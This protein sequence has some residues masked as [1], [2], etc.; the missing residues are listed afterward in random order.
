MFLHCLT[1]LTLEFGGLLFTAC[2]QISWKIPFS[3]GAFGTS[4]DQLYDG[5]LF[6][7]CCNKGSFSP[8]LT[9]GGRESWCRVTFMF[10]IF[11]TILED[12]YSHFLDSSD[13]ACL[14]EL[15]IVTIYW[16]VISRNGFLYLIIV[17]SNDLS[18]TE[19]CSSIL[20]FHHLIVLFIFPGW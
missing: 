9:Y 5:G 7:T 10:L 3:C 6:W 14:F 17:S 1:L 16:F 20:I 15:K 2:K 12:P 18:I 11:S 4:P 19:D 13:A 8:K